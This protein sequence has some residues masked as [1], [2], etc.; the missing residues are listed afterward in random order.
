[1]KNKATLDLKEA[2]KQ[3]YTLT[4]V[5]EKGRVAHTSTIAAGITLVELPQVAA[6]M[7]L[8][9]LGS[10]QQTVLTKKWLVTSK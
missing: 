5:D 3:A 7:Y 2:T 1:M 8:V 6:G 9:S 4:V 10:E